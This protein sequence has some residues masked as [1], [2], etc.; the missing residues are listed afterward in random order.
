MKLKKIIEKPI[1][2]KD[3]EKL[4]WLYS[5]IT[6]L[7]EKAKKAALERDLEFMEKKGRFLTLE[8]F[9]EILSKKKVKP[10]LIP[11]KYKREMERYH[12]MF[13]SSIAEMLK[14][15]ELQDAKIGKMLG[16]PAAKENLFELKKKG[17]TIGFVHF[18]EKEKTIDFIADIKDLPK[19]FK[20]KLKKK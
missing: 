1:K 17:K 7:N 3:I 12:Q 9:H 4:K 18:N 16:L 20:K 10:E 13:T 11:E 2:K 19:E 15:D 14:L 5:G 6:I 8:E